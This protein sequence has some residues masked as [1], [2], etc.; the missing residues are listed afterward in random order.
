MNT[1]IEPKKMN[2][3]WFIKYILK[4]FIE[5]LPASLKMFTVP[6]KTLIEPKKTLIEK[7]DF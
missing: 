4:C 2:M 1:L 5:A 3:E 6:K 7:N